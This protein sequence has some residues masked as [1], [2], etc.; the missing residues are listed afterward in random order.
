MSLQL[1]KAIVFLQVLFCDLTTHQKEVSLER[2]QAGGQRQSMQF[3]SS[4]YKQY[5]AS[6]DVNDILYGKL[7][8]FVG[9]I[10]LRKLC[11]HPDLVTGGPNRDEQNS[12]EDI[13]AEFGATGRSVCERQN[14]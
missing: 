10:T 4:L 8:A 9:L 5:I 12:S 3:F 1:S 13:D 7:D 2:Q 14:I 11:N 6:K